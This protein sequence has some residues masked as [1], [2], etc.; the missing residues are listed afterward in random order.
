MKIALLGYG[1]MGKTIEQIA[2]QRNHEISYRIDVQNISDLQLLSKKNTDV[3]I[4]FTSPH[5]AY[6]NVR[7]CVD[8]QIPVVCGTTGWLDK[9]TEIEQACLKQK[10]AF[11]Y[12][13][14]YSIG[15]N[16]F[17]QIN[18]ILAKMMNNYP[19]FDVQMEEIH[20]TQKLDKPSG[21][22]V[23]LAEG[24]MKNI[25]RKTEWA[26][27]PVIDSKQLEINALREENVFGIHSVNY[28]SAIDTIEIKHTAHSRQGFATGAVLAAEFL[29]GKTGI[30]GMNDLLAL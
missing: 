16:I 8:Q 6:A 30:F 29:A 17:F 11:F 3:A 5:S 28:T 23:T 9:K 24:I 4:E 26:L 20:H 13:S 7:F 2:L 14:N 10:S 19:D 1:K 15:V 25:F 12:A 27:S 18:E 21:T 22:A